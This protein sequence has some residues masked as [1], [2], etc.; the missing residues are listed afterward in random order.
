MI[1]SANQIISKF[2]PEVKDGE[3]IPDVC[4]VGSALFLGPNI[5]LMCCNKIERIGENKD[6]EQYDCIVNEIKSYSSSSKTRMKDG[7]AISEL[8]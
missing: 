2:A 3:E 6:D 5:R 8:N 4:R 1:E 7:I